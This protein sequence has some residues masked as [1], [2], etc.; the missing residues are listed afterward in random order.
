[1]EAGPPECLLFTSSK[2]EGPFSLTPG[3]C[4]ILERTRLPRTKQNPQR[5]FPISDSRK[6]PA[7]SST[8]H[9]HGLSMALSFST[10]W[11]FSTHPFSFVSPSVQAGLHLFVFA[12]SA[13]LPLSVPPSALAGFSLS[14]RFSLLSSWLALSKW[15]S[16]VPR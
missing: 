7:L 8:S 11:H 10:C 2:G 14:C 9:I 16:A 3:S 4:R 6:L 1:M 12:G 13:S 5:F 15:L